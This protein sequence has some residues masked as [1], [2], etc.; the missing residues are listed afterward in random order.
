M[1]G[2]PQHYHLDGTLLEAC[3]CA[4]PCPC[5]VG[6]DPDGGHCE[7]MNAYHVDHGTIEGVD[8]A[9]LSLVQVIKIP[10][11]VLNGHWRE[12][13]FVDARATQAQRDALVAA[14]RGQL[15]GP[16]ATLAALVEDQ[17]A[18][19]S[20]PM[21]YSAQRGY[22]TLR[23][24]VKAT[25]TM[26]RAVPSAAPGPAQPLTIGTKV[27][28]TIQTYHDARGE[29]TT[30]ANSPFSAIPGSPAYLGEAPTYEVNVPEH[31]M[32]WTFSGRNAVQGAFHFEA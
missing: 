9:G 24:D 5:W 8:V 25:A 17:V 1:S 22:G 11:N 31:G 2:R 21:D 12:V 10:G 19:Y 14:F 28:A 23:V 20:A 4:S 16:L 13:I 6:R 30:L 18:I 27:T 3:S 15:G 32:V 29:L 26:G 7:A